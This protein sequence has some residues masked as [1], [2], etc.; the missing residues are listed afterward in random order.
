MLFGYLI[1]W[2]IL[3]FLRKANLILSTVGWAYLSA[4]WL[5]QKLRIQSFRNECDPSQKKKVLVF[6][7]FRSVM[8]QHESSR[9]CVLSGKSQLI[10]KE[11]SLRMK[12]RTYQRTISFCKLIG[13]KMHKIWLKA[14][15]NLVEM[16]SGIQGTIPDTNL[17]DVL[18]A[19]GVHHRAVWRP[20]AKYR[21]GTRLP[22][23]IV[24]AC[25]VRCFGTKWR[26]VRWRG[27]DIEVL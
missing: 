21:D 25:A 9:H 6:S 20:D 15:K 26:A 13:R 18:A 12:D 10:R 27:I 5:T 22:A 4:E 7:C 23:L 17:R 3:A 24:R 16:S 19:W 8:V 1:G 14:I 11:T 2:N